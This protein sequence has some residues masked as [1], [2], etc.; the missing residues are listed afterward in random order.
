MITVLAVAAVWVALSGLVCAFVAGTSIRIAG[1][2]PSVT[3]APVWLDLFESASPQRPVTATVEA[4]AAVEA[5]AH[6]VHVTV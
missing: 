3:P 6:G 2:E 4:A 1:R 5:A